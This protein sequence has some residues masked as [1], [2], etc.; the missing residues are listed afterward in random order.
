[1]K[2]IISFFSLSAI[3]KCIKSTVMKKII[4]TLVIVQCFLS[5]AE[6]QW[7]KQFSPNHD[8]RDIEFIDRYTGWTCGENYIYK[9]TDGGISWNKQIHPDAFLIQQIF[10]VNDSVVYACG[11]WN[12]MKTTNGGQN[13]TAFFAGGT[14]Q[15]LPV[16]EG[17]YFINE[18][19]GWLVGNVVAMKT[20]NGGNSFTDSM[21]VEAIAQDVYFKDA[22]TGIMCGEVAGF[23]KTTN[24]GQ[25]WNRIQVIQTGPLYDFYRIS[26]INDSLVWI[27]S[28]QIFKST[29]FGSTWDSIG[30]Y[31]FHQINNYVFCIEF[32]SVLTGY[33]GGATRDLFK[34][35]NGGS[36]W[37]PQN[38]TNYI[39]GLYLGLYAYNDSIVWSS[40]RRLILNTVTGGIVTI[41]NQTSS[42]KYEFHLYENFP[43][44]FN[45]KTT[46]K[47]SIKLT[48]LVNITLYNISG[49]KINT[50]L[51]EKKNKGIYELEFDGSHLSSGVYFL[52]FEIDNKIFESKKIMIVK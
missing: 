16:L 27:G 8:L 51:Q 38:L 45:P 5:I 13:W 33:A 2:K 10:P 36:D 34:S 18:N 39:P 32:S 29:D 30:I 7:V 35:T 21:R 24:G 49:K 1:M 31:P 50:L 9:T 15:G 26:V 40:G 6:G 17:L 23:Y 3:L 42:D 47:Y 52:L 22:L 44:P 43:N 46:I 41:N 25:N 4:L 48:S 11:W 37:I 19:T 12:F 14:G 20:T 28:N